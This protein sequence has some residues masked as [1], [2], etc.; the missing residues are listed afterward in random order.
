VRFGRRGERRP[1]GVEEAVEAVRRNARDLSTSDDLDRLVATASD[2]SVVLVGEA[3]HGTS[4]FYRWRA[5]LTARLVRESDVAFVGVE[6][7]WTDCYEVNRYVG[8]HP[9]APEEAAAVLSEFDRWPTWL[10]ANWE[11]A[12]FLRWLREYNAGRSASEQVGFYGLDVYGLSESMAAVIDYL[13]DVDPEAAERARDAYQCFE[14]YGEDAREYGRSASLVPDDCEEEV[15]E[16]LSDLRRGDGECGDSDES[17]FVAEQN[18]LVAKNAESY[19]RSMIRGDS[20]SWNVRDR[21][22]TDTLDRLLERATDGRTAVVWA[23]NTHVGDARATDMRERGAVNVGQLARERYGADDVHLVGFGTHRGSVV[24]GRAWGEPMERMTVPPAR[25]TSYG[26]V[27]HRADVGDSTL[28]FDDVDRSGRSALRSPRGQRA[29]G[30]V[31][32]PERELGNYVPT[33]LPERYDSFVHV[34]ESS[35]LH[36]LHLDPGGSEPPE[37]F[38]WGV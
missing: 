11:V 26:D 24:A 20:A 19:Y 3:S 28:V 10:W 5:R 7:D 4:E 16:V 18:A 25:E 14:P 38:P 1:D 34:E 15:I 12:E 32:R 36:P 22:M 29:V 6:G 17:R 33:V 9:D 21:H 30:V 27:F 31:Y 2:A 13:E 23:H 8:G 37:T 35:A